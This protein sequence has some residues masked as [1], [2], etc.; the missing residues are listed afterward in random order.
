MNKSLNL[1][2]SIFNI[3]ERSIRVTSQPKFTSVLHYSVKLRERAHVIWHAHDIEHGGIHGYPGCF[4][5]YTWSS[6]ELVISQQKQGTTWRLFL[7]SYTSLGAYFGRRDTSYQDETAV[8]SALTSHWSFLTR[9]RPLGESVLGLAR[10]IRNV[11]LANYKSI[12]LEELANRS[13]GG[14]IFPKTGWI[15]IQPGAT[16]TLYFFG[17]FPDI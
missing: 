10:R 12:F 17:V 3:T 5:C 1:Y 15:V 4:S 2:N 6:Y 11:V 13:V 7:L 14:G 9:F 16:D 8:N